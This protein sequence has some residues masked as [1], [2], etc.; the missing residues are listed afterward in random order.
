MS[1][2]HHP[3]EH[4]AEPISLAAAGCLSSDEQQPVRR[5]I[6]TCADCRE[7]LRQ[8]TELC[9]ALVEASLAS[10]S[11][12]GALLERIMSAVTADVARRPGVRTREEMIHPSFVF[13]SLH[14]WRWIMRSPVS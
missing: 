2:L 1:D 3:C 14:V 12:E 9:R 4:W 10:D 11:T 6:E 7:Q 8:L 13:R 5:H